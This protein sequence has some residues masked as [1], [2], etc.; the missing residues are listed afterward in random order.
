MQSQKVNGLPAA[1]KEGNGDNDQNCVL[2]YLAA[3]CLCRNMSNAKST[4]TMLEEDV[5]DYYEAGNSTAPS[6]ET[7]HKCFIHMLSFALEARAV[8]ASYLMP[9]HQI[10]QNLINPECHTV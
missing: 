4:D 7:A 9:R 8:L 5:A 3:R 6:F 10:H 1:W 2:I